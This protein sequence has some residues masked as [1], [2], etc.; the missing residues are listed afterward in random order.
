MAY[1]R[2]C[3]EVIDDEAVICP[4]CGVQQKEYKKASDDDGSILW[5]LLGLLIPIAG[6]ILWIMWKDDKPKSARMA[7][8]GFLA[9]II[10]WIVGVAAMFSLVGLYMH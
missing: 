7:G 8:I 3:G 6:L 2:K 4:K 5:L 9:N 1:C 10:F